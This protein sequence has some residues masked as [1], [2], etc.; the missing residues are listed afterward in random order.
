MAEKKL[1]DGRKLVYV[2]GFKIRNFIDDDFGVIHERSQDINKFVPKFYI[3]E[4][5]IWLDRRYADELEFLYKAMVFEPP[6]PIASSLERRAA[7]K[8]ELCLPGPVPKVAVEKKKD[9]ELAIVMVDG[10]NVRAYID[11][12][13]ILGGHEFVYDYVPNGEIWIDVKTDPSEIPYILLHEKV[14]RELMVKGKS[15]DVAH[16]YATISDKEE[17]RAKAEAK[18]P[19]DADYPWYGKENGDIISNIIIDN[20]HG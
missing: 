12:E 4:N 20:N 19:G 11:P 7:I 15:Y 16:E 2:D 3:P 6:M 17:R 9:G 14:E 18:Y 10:K 13:F 1:P 8:K 5:E